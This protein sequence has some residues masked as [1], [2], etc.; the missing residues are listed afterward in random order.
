MTTA[1]PL[2]LTEITQTKEPTMRETHLAAALDYILDSGETPD[3]QLVDT[4][5]DADPLLFA[6]GARLFYVSYSDDCGYEVWE[7]TKLTSEWNY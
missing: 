7:E 5:E 1:E 6:F 2:T 3:G 4:S